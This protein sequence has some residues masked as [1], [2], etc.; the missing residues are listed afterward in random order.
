MKGKEPGSVLKAYYTR[1]TWMNIDNIALSGEKMGEDCARYQCL[2]CQL[3]CHLELDPVNI[4][5]CQ[6]VQ[7]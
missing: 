4:L 2:V 3:Q 6:L 1:R 7:C 5:I